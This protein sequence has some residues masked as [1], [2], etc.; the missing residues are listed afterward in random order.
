MKYLER[1]PYPGVEFAL[2]RA[3]VETPDKISDDEAT[4]L[5]RLS[6]IAD[7]W[8]TFPELDPEFVDMEIWR[9]RYAR[10]LKETL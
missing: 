5:D 9:E 3:V 1:G 10:S 6:Y 8:W 4:D 2:W 7:G